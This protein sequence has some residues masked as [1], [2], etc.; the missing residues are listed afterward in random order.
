MDGVPNGAPVSCARILRQYLAPLLCAGSGF[1]TDDIFQPGS[2]R[3]QAAV[4]T[5]RPDQ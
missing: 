2:N 4:M 3:Q 5:M 1:H